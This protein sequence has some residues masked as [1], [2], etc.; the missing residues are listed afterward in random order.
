[1]LL[2]GNFRCYLDRAPLPVFKRRRE[3]E[4]E[5]GLL[6]FKTDT[7]RGKLLSTIGDKNIEKHVCRL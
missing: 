3:A 7:Y 2:V 1:M 6:S 5:N 4:T